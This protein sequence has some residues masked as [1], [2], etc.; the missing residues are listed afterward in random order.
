MGIES[1]LALLEKKLIKDIAGNI[2]IIIVM[3]VG[4]KI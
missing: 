4:T 1:K 2:F 3:L